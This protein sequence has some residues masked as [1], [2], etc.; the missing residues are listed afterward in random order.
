MLTNLLAEFGKEKVAEYGAK[1]SRTR[2]PGIILFNG[3][4]PKRFGL[5]LHTQPSLR[6]W[7]RQ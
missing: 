2:Y 4:L 5:T 1:L 7:L 3:P 6:L